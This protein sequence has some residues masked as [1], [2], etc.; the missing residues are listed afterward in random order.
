MSVQTVRGFAVCVYADT[1][2]AD[3]L[4]TIRYVVDWKCGSTHNVETL[5][6]FAQTIGDLTHHLEVAKVAGYEGDVGYRTIC[7]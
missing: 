5:F 2:A 7:G 4:V 1:G 3:E 6:V